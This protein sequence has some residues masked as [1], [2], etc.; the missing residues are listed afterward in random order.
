MRNF[1]LMVSI[2]FGLVNFCYSEEKIHDHGYW[3]G[4]EIIDQHKFDLDLAEALSK[5]FISEKAK[6]IVDFGCGIGDYVK[7]L[8]SVDLDCKGYDGNPD[9]YELTGG[10][11]NIIDLSQPFDLDR[12]FDWVLCLEVGEH[13]PQCYESIFIENLDKHN[14]QGIV[15]SWAVKGQGGFGHF[16]E[17]N[18][19]FIKN[20]MLNLGYSN[21]ELSEKTLRENSSLPWFKNTIMVFRKNK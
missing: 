9:T 15:L 12:C 2:F 4:K 8:R 13:L 20:I 16:N 5:F 14:T 11:A 19:D 7:Y 18:N 17:Q 21:D 6:T 3:C 10:I 1:Y